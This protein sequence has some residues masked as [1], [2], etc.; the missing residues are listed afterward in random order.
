MSTVQRYGHPEQSISE[1]A[2]ISA[3]VR[4]AQEEIEGKQLR[5]NALVTYGCL[6]PNMVPLTFSPPGPL[7][8][9]QLGRSYTYSAGVTYI[10]QV[11]A[12]YIYFVGVTY[13]ARAMYT[14]SARAT[15]TYLVHDIQGRL[16]MSKKK[17]LFGWR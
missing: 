5:Q 10:Y 12:S 6:N 14:Y 8:L 15:Y 11:M 13:S 7:I 1:C 3:N 2:Q 16:D 17:V 9:I 4:K